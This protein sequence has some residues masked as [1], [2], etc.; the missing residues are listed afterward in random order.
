[1]M[2]TVM[3]K[4]TEVANKANER[5]E[6]ITKE[7]F[8]FAF[9][10]VEI[11]VTADAAGVYIRSGNTPIASEPRKG[12]PEAAYQR[13][14]SAIW[15]VVDTTRNAV[16]RRRL[17]KKEAEEL[18]SEDSEMSAAEAALRAAGV[19]TTILGK[20]DASAAKEVLA[21]AKA[22]VR[23][24]NRNPFVG[25][26]PYGEYKLSVRGYSGGV[27]IYAGGKPCVVTHYPKVFNNKTLVDVAGFLRETIQSLSASRRAYYARVAQAAE[28]ERKLHA[29]SM[30]M[31][32]ASAALEAAAM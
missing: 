24:A 31:E 16:E 26:I 8:P 17:L 29:V 12:S 14:K 10:E 27:V 22:A 19:D 4:V 6:A 23:A 11:V 18:K 30:Q 25:T 2:N 3:D 1:M 9:S 21:A 7:G 15:E 5:L 13:L 32:D 20:V 28:R